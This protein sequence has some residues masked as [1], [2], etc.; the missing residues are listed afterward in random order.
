MT[1]AL[2]I[3]LA[4]LPSAHLPVPSSPPAVRVRV[5]AKHSPRYVDCASA[6]GGGLV[7]LL[8]PGQKPWRKQRLSFDCRSRDTVCL[9]GLQTSICRRTFQLR[10][11]RPGA[12]I[13][14]KAGNLPR[15]VYEGQLEITPAGGSCQVV[16]ELPVDDY[17]EAVA[18]AEMPGAPRQALLAQAIAARSYALAS[19]VKHP[20]SG[21]DFCDLT[22]CQ[23]YLGR[24]AC[25][26]AAKRHLRRVRGLVLTWRQRPAE[27]VYFSTC[28]GHTASARDIWGHG[29]DRVY[30]RGVPD[31]SGPN[32]RKS[33]HL[34]WRL[35]VSAGRLCALLRQRF[36][37]LGKADDGD[38]RVQVEEVGVGGWVRKVQVSGMIRKHMSG[39]EFHLL[40][41]RQLG[42]GRFKSARFTIERQGGR[43]VF[44]GR[45]L[46]HGVG[47]CQYGAMGL[48][49]QGLD[50]RQ[51]LRHYY[52]HTSLE[53]WW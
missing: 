52:P 53:K 46:G 18:C 1:A 22:H 6:G 20:G 8:G 33:P 17:A 35:E 32:C 31:G 34:S 28:A 29:A 50:Y 14:V 3:M 47:M 41:G 16:N 21:Y 25:S 23:H 26:P 27:A 42:W 37:R 43:Y 11:G 51:I 19:L 7:L 48:A 15:R 40:L 38:C 39:E 49:R 45:G 5:L 10:P 12:G 2:L 30:L 13:S 9:Q 36:P 4:A 24:G 44:R